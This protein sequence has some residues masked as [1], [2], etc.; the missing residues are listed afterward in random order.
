MAG[1]KAKG[2]QTIAAVLFVTVSSDI[3]ICKGGSIWS[4]D[5]V[6]K[7]GSVVGAGRDQ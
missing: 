6:T 3:S 1:G 4:Y 5:S 2:S 7:H